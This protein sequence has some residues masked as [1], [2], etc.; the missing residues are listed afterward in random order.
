MEKARKA[1]ARPGHRFCEGCREIYPESCF[2]MITKPGK[3]VGR[4]RCPYCTTIEVGAGCGG[5]DQGGDCT[6]IVPA[7]W[8]SHERG[9]VH[10]GQGVLDI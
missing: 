5:C 1:R 7:R 3:T 2:F 8:R 6:C 9:M 10:P 4:K